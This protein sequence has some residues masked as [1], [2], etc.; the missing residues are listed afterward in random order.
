M[1]I[2]ESHLRQVIRA[3]INEDV[4][5]GSGMGVAV[6][7]GNAALKQDRRKIVEDE[8]TKTYDWFK[9][10]VFPAVEGNDWP[11]TADQDYSI[12]FMYG[13]MDGAA[14]PN[15]TRRYIKKG[16]NFLSADEKKQYG[17]APEDRLAASNPSS[18]TE[19]YSELEDSVLSFKLSVP[20]ESF[21]D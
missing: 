1:R 4:N 9:N 20:M 7:K 2:T 18:L 3:V 15:T 17:F 6:Q 16:T 19:L 21:P 14:D 8:L 10:T 13:A 5:L 11:I 12:S